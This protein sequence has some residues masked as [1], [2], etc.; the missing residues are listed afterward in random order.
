MNM[1]IVQL[2]NEYN[3]SNRKAD[4]EF[5]QRFLDIVKRTY[6]LDGYLNELIYSS[7]YRSYRKLATLIDFYTFLIY[8]Y[9]YLNNS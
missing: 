3:A 6:G 9:I 1:E 4:F 8:R 2:V 5:Y 7:I